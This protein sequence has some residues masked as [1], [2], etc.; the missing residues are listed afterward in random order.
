MRLSETNYDNSET[1]CCACLKRQDYDE[2]EWIW[3]DTTDPFRIG[4]RTREG[5]FRLRSGSRE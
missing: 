2:K 4:A 3:K 5:S 1:G